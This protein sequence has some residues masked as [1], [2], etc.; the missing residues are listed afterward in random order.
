MIGWKRIV[1]TVGEKIGKSHMSYSQGAAAELVAASTIGA[2]AY[3]GLPVSTT[4]V[5]SSGIAGTMIAQKSG[6]QKGTVR[7]IALAWVLTLPASMLLAAILFAVFRALIPG[8]PDKIRPTVDTTIARQDPDATPAVQVTSTEPTLRLHGSNTI[9]ARLAPEL[10]EAFFLSKGATE[11]TRRAGPA[12]ASWI[13]TARIPGEKSPRLIEIVA[14]GSGTAFTDL[15][16]HKCD[17]GLSSRRV[18]TEEAAKIA[19]AGL[20]DPRAPANE[21]VF[22][23]D[24]IA[25]VVNAHNRLRSASVAE[26]ARIFSGESA[27]F[28]ESGGNAVVY[29]RDE[30]SGTF[31]VF[32]T[33]VLGE[34]RLARGT[35]RFAENSAL[36]EAVAADEHA[37]GFVPMSAVQSAKALAV[38]ASAESAV[39]PS[40]FS[41]G[42]E[43]Y[44]LSRRLYL[45]TTNATAEDALGPQLV[46]FALSGAG[47]RVVDEAGFVDLSVRARPGEP[48]DARCPASYA[49]LTRGAERLSVDFRFQTG[50][51][52]LDTRAL[53]DVARVTAYVS[54]HGARKVAL[55]GFSDS[56]GSSEVN[57]QLSRERAKTVDG[58]LRERGVQATAVD[59]FGESMPVASNATPEGREHN[60]RVEVWLLAE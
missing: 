20:G 45:Y 28:P 57:E 51:S 42:T 31:D 24:G 46:A 33:L 14:G 32:R 38:G 21:H 23:L 6:L 11:V 7:T 58:V 36:A 8:S 48:C 1:V 49:A 30:R 59:G 50:T 2:S 53:E 25:I 10:A 3:L 26:L 52:A 54:E 16:D 13:V 55:I 44:P 47:Q 9:G 17:I 39:V 35:K 43:D 34:R 4:H 18:T 41:V 22:G 56:V 37:I 19:A 12:L 60:R 29:A 40:T 5:L 15:A 27:D